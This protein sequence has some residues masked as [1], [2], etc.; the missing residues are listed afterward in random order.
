MKKIFWTSM[1]LFIF[2]CVFAANFNVINE[3]NYEFLGEINLAYDNQSLKTLR[4]I[5]IPGYLQ[6]SNGEKS[7]IKKD[8][9]ALKANDKNLK[10]S[11]YV[12]GA[13]KIDKDEYEFFELECEQDPNRTSENI[14]IT[15]N[16]TGG[17]CYIKYS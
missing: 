10:S 7:S 2:P 3:S 13:L 15:I 8:I 5:D 4:I 6:L 1:V 16:N 17:S 14:L 11:F 12:L 9:P